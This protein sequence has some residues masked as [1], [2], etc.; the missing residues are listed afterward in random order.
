[1]KIA[2]FR[3]KNNILWGI[4]NA[5]GTITC[6]KKEPFDRIEISAKKISLKK[7][8]LLPPAKPTKIILVGLNYKDHAQELTMPVPKEPIIFMKPPTSLSAHNEKVILPDG[9]KQLDYEAELA[10]VIKKKAKNITQN[11]YHKYILGYTALN[12]ITARD[13]QSKDVQWTRAKSFDGFCPIGPWLETEFNPNNARIQLYLNDILRQNSS[14]VNF[15]FSIG[16]IVSFISKVMTLSP[17]DVISTGTPP[18]VGPMKKGDKVQVFI[19][20]IGYL[21]NYIV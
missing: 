18:G 20:G 14:T 9:V 3:Y 15:V 12:D 21:T 17:G 13:L 1:M 8:K 11:N 16:Y 5:D 2:K 4:I 19:Q 6:L 10:L 7:I